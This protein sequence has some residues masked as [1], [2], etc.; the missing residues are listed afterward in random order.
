[1]HV[2]KNID[3]YCEKICRLLNFEWVRLNKHKQDSVR[4]PFNRKSIFV[5]YPEGKNNYLLPLFNDYLK[6]TFYIVS[7]QDRSNNVDCGVFLCCY[8]FGIFKLKEEDIVFTNVDARTEV[9]G[10][11]H[12]KCT[13]EGY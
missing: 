5:L 13:I 8:A 12:V 10:C 11:F 4:V 6:L 9:Y 1:M 2:Y 7:M 3:L